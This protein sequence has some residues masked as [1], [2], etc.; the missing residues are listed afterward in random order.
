LK[1]LSLNFRE[2]KKAQKMAIPRFFDFSNLC[3]LE[4]SYFFSRLVFTRGSSFEIG[5]K[6]SGG[7]IKIK[8]KENH[9]FN[10]YHLQKNS[11]L[12]FLTTEAGTNSRFV[13]LL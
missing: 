8:N 4:W 11:N 7:S 2:C 5:I 6:I 10:L 12:Y 3:N 13:S 1:N 9:W